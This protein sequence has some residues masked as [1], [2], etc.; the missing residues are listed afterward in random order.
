MTAVTMATRVT[1]VFGS[2]PIIATV[3]R[4]TSTTTPTAIAIQNTIETFV[5]MG[6]TVIAMIG[7]T[8]VAMIVISS[9]VMICGGAGVS[10]GVA[11][12]ATKAKRTTTT[13]VNAFVVASA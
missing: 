2:I 13:R 10:S 8:I 12:T 6:A 4:S 7:A 1:T 5:T 11:I 3:M 9:F